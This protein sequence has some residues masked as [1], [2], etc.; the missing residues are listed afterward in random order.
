MEVN[1]RES[2]IEQRL[3]LPLIPELAD[4][5]GRAARDHAQVLLQAGMSKAGVRS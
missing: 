1:V 2:W 3:A 5:V 4:A